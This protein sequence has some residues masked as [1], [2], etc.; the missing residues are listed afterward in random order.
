MDSMQTFREAVAN[1]LAYA[2]E[3]HRTKDRPLMGYLCSYAPEELILAAGLHPFRLFGARGNIHRAD[4]HLQSYCC[5]LVRGVLEEALAGKLGFLAGVI[6]PHTCDS[7]Q[8]LSDIW[9]LQAITPFHADL[10]LPVKLNTESAKIYLREVLSRL[11]SEL[12]AWRG[13]TITED[14]LRG[15]IAVMNRVRRGL[16]DIFERRS[17]SPGILSGADLQ[18]IARASFLLDRRELS[19][20]LARIGDDLRGKGNGTVDNGRKRLVLAGGF[21]DL[22]EIYGIIEEAGADVVGDDL[23]TGARAYGGMI[24]EDKEPL[25]AMTE[26]YLTRPCCPAK[27]QGLTGRGE[28]LLRLVR[29]KEADGVV[30]TWLKFCDPHAFDYPYLK[31]FLDQAGIPS[32]VLELED[33]LPGEGQLQ[34]RFEAFIETI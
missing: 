8:R 24:D 29:E 16:Q 2:E 13:I 3:Y 22:P 1:P 25:L 15:A 21:C 30:F 19:D 17:V 28:H 6:F 27:H 31:A 9:R 34:T 4:A 7:I 18:S 14:D 23:C 12:E 10:V 11:K 32:L 5:S 33:Q 26:R 20:Q